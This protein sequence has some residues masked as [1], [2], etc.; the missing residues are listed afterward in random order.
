MRGR[1]KTQNN[2]PEHCNLIEEQK[3]LSGLGFV[4]HKSSRF[5]VGFLPQAD[6]SLYFFSKASECVEHKSSGYSTMRM[7]N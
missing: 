3:G 7:I 4:C 5:R 1:P 2:R 6:H